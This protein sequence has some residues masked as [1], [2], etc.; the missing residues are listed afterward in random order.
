MVDTLTPEQRSLNMSRIRSTGNKSTELKM[1]RAMTENGITGWRRKYPA[2]GKPDFVFPPQK[3]AVFVDGCFWHGHPTLCR[4]PS[5]NVEFWQKKIARNMG[6]DRE[7]TEFLTR[8]GWRVIRVWENEV[9][10][11]QT[12]MRL[13]DALGLCPRRSGGKFGRRADY[14]APWA[15]SFEP[16][17]TGVKRLFKLSPR[18][19]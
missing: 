14:Q 3:T 4:M 12:I 6:R 16:S 10:S 8:K 17:G 18:K 15:L 9:D 2:R 13:R 7:V 19:R 1:I 5:S 11:P